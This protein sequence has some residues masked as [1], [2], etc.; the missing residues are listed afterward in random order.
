L[1]AIIPATR[2]GE[3]QGNCEPRSSHEY[4]MIGD[5]SRV[6][7]RELSITRLLNARR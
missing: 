5:S 6:D 2:A 1:N 7:S 4:P 3:E